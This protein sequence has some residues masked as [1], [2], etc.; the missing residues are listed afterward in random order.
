MKVNRSGSNLITFYAPLPWKPVAPARA[1]GSGP[2]STRNYGSGL[3]PSPAAAKVRC[4]GSS[5][6]S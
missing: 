4:I 1:C 3:G 6:A 2:A 5:A